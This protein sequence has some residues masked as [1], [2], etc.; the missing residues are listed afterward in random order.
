[1]LY[2][3]AE[4]DLIPALL[5]TILVIF[6]NLNSLLSKISMIKSILEDHVKIKRDLYKLLSIVLA[7]NKAH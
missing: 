3:W 6:L 4:L 7:H 1:M 2:C 5:I